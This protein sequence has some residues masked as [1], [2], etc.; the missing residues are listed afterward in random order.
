[1]TDFV[2]LSDGRR[3]GLAVYGAE[4]GLPVLALHGAPASRLMF[5]V[6]DAPAKKFGL[7]LYCPER[8]GYGVTA[9]DTG[10]TLAT[11]ARDLGEIADKLG[12]DRFGVLGV[13]GGGPYAVALAELMGQRVAAIALVSPMGPI[14]QFLDAQKR[15]EV[16]P[17]LGRVG[18]GHRVFFIELAKHRSVLKAQ[19][20]ISAR[21]FKAAPQM[22]AKLFARI[23]SSDDRRILSQPHV[24]ESQVRMT[25]EALR[26]GVDG[27]LADMAIFAKPWPVDFR[28][29]SA[30]AILWQGDEDR[31]VP[32]PA[33]LWLS[34][35]IEGCRLVKLRGAGHFWVYDHVGD[36]LEALAGMMPVDLDGSATA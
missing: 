32:V 4:D 10:A 13:S 35:L 14:A 16:D 3:F 23:L 15:G 36:V 22:F 1:M 12:L 27:G 31:V 5:D 21:A 29:I 34:G 18:R 8:P 9:A 11:R 6:A 26:H 17:R 20:V 24:R 28:N 7:R 33:S 19:S 2:E 30:P 25:L